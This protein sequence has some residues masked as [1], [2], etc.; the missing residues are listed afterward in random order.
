MAKLGTATEIE[1]AKQILADA[2]EKGETYAE[3][4]QTLKD[5]LGGNPSFKPGYWETVFRTNTQSAYMAGKLQKYEKTG[6]AAYQLMVVEDSRTSKI[7]K[8]LLTASGYGMILPVDHPFWKK[9]G[10]PGYH[11]N[12]RTSICPIYP[13]QIGKMG[14]NV[15]NPSMSHFAKFKPQSEFGG[16]PLDKESWW[17]MTDSMIKR[18][19]DF[20]IW[21]D[22][23]QQ[24]FNMDMRSYQK[25]LLQGYELAYKGHRG[26]YVQ[27][28]KNWEYSK[29]EM[30]AAQ[31]LAIE[32]HQVYLL[33]RNNLA[34]KVKSPDCLIDNEIGEFK[35]QETM[36][37]GAIE[38]EIKKA[39]KQ[40]ARIVYLKALDDMP[41]EE[42]QNG[43]KSEVLRSPIKI[44]YLDWKGHMRKLS[45][46][47]IREKKW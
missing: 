13:S 10:Y 12:C 30:D 11:F 35:H 4:W 19:E 39:K 23:L 5:S 33:P 18:A 15:D 40:R 47:V 43:L 42:I 46:K 8:H 22:I 36:S 26:G 6:V 41:K 21:A 17:K 31:K 7:C 45:R 32:G 25:E 16:N 14:I 27:K 24:A 3:S 37:K 2:V 29:K 20:G 44:V 28:A 9:Y 34:K 38:H 1:T